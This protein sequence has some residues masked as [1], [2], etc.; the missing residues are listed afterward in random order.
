MLSSWRAFSVL[1]SLLAFST[2]CFSG[3]WRA[4]VTDLL[5]SKDKCTTSGD[6]TSIAA[7][8]TCKI[9]SLGSWLRRELDWFLALPLLASLVL[10]CPFCCA[11]SAFNVSPRSSLPRDWRWLFDLRLARVCSSAALAFLSS[12]SVRSWRS[13]PLLFSLLSLPLRPLS[14]RLLRLRSLGRLLS[15][16]RLSWLLDCWLFDSLL[17]ALFVLLSIASASL[18]TLSLVSSD[19]SFLWRVLEGLDLRGLRLLLSSASLSSLEVLLA[20]CWWLALTF[21]DWLLACWLLS[22]CAA[23][24]WLLALSAL[25]STWP[26]EPKLCAPVLTRASMASAASRLL[27]LWEVCACGAWANK[28]DNQATACGWAAATGVF[29]VAT[30][31]AVATTAGALCVGACVCGCVCGARADE[32][33]LALALLRWSLLWLVVFCCWLGALCWSLALV[34]AWLLLSAI[35]RGWRVGCCSGRSFSAVCQSTS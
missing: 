22:C 23:E 31:A 34:V 19:G 29:W 9:T 14:W 10:C 1:A 3:V 8:L 12:A 5:S 11:L 26:N 24:A 15:C 27:T 25:L 33:L 17:S 2:L 32:T 4:A 16:W 35:W 6:L 28:L 18:V 30:G 7:S 20:V 13:L 21:D